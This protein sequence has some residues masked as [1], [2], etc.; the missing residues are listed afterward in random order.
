[1]TVRCSL[2]PQ[3]Q[4]SDRKHNRRKPVAMRQY[5]TIRV[6]TQILFDGTWGAG[7]I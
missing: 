3:R 2:R 6:C 7:R 4:M 5:L 1:M